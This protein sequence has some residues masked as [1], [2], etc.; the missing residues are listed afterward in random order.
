MPVDMDLEARTLRTLLALRKLTLLHVTKR[1]KTL[2]IASGPEDDP[3]P[4]VRLALVGRGQWRLDLRHHAGRWDKTPI[5]G[6]MDDMVA[7][8]ADMGRLD[9]FS[10]PGSWNQGDTSDPSH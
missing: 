1:A 9:D 10:L 5:V 8:A 7:A 3:D 6:D 2:T 4:E